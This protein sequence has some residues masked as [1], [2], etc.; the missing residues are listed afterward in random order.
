MKTRD[1]CSNGKHLNANLCCSLSE[2]SISI[3]EIKFEVE[4]PFLTL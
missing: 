1:H 3:S 2:M 4:D